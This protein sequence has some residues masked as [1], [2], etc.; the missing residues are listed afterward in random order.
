MDIQDA[1][2]MCSLQ[3]IKKKRDRERERKSSFDLKFV[4][5]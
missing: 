5:C 3:Q 2:D 1:H 4:T